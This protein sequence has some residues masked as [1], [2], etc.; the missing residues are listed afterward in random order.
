V[1]RKFAET[2]V[3]ETLQIE[4]DR[5]EIIWTASQKSDVP[6]GADFQTQSSSAKTVKPPASL[7]SSTGL[8]TGD[9]DGHGT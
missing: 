8:P 1:R 4:F 9:F 3:I 2:P 5:E 6:T 7:K